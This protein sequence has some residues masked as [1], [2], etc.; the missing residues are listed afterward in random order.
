MRSPPDAPQILEQVDRI[1]AD[2]RLAR[3]PILSRLLRFVVDETLAGRG[4][5]LKEYVLG[6]EVCGRPPAYDPRLD[7]IVRVQ[8][9]ELRRRLR[10]Y[11]ETGGRHDPVVIDLPKGHY[12]ATFRLVDRQAPEA[13]PHESQIEPPA[14]HANLTRPAL[15]IGFGAVVLVVVWIGFGAFRP[16]IEKIGTAAPAPPSIA[17]LPFVNVGGE[18]DDNYLGD[19]MTE[20]I[21]TAAAN[22]DGLRVL[23]R[24]SVFRF[25]GVSDN[26]R[27]IA[28]QLK[29]DAIVSGSVR[30]EGTRLRIAARLV[31]AVDGAILW[32]ETF[33]GE[34]S[35]LFNVQERI[36]RAIATALSVR[37]GGETD[38]H[39]RGSTSDAEA[40][41]LYL[42]GRY[43]WN[44]RTHD[45]LIKA[46]DLFEQAVTRDPQYAAA[47]AGLAEAHI[48]SIWY[49][50]VPPKVAIPRAK[51]AA[52][53]AVSLAPALA[54]AH[55]ALG[56]VHMMEWDWVG[57]VRSLERAMAIAPDFPRAQH[58]YAYTML[59]TNRPHE[60]VAAMRRAQ[61]LDPLSLVVNADLGEVLDFAGHTDEALEQARKTVE[62]DPNFAITHYTLERAL[63]RKGQTQEALR[64]RLKGDELAGLPPEE[65][66]A[67]KDAA[68]A[69]GWD[70]YYSKRIEQLTNARSPRLYEVGRCYTRLGKLDD[71]FQWFERAYQQHDG[72]LSNIGV[73][74]AAVLRHDPRFVSLQ[75]KMG[76]P[77]RGLDTVTTH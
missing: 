63:H 70:A 24:T 34:R 18:P 1:L 14:E 53:S 54:E 69:G 66:N 52:L 71:A 42:K 74:V 16:F 72:T 48:M 21:I 40:R 2:A 58:L 11:Y 65:V 51:A 25:S 67:L 7:P 3:S 32:S 49:A 43:F 60:A 64:E 30:H 57:A 27:E 20:E 62:M 15:A 4:D 33:E 12:V 17:V 10:E 36:A 31:R 55:A 9:R 23:G 13:A 19:G 26:E 29:V 73:E 39:V 37:L 8:T 76:L 41:T 77:E 50:F 6:L 38:R 45:G 59:L 44:K 75:R 35:D 61:Q 68:T 22:V 28:R 46:L 47:F 5:R 56:S